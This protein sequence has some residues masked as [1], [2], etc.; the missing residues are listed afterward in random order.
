MKVLHEDETVAPDAV[1]LLI[2]VADKTDSAMLVC[3]FP[4]DNRIF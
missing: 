2:V 1:L 4:L 3:I